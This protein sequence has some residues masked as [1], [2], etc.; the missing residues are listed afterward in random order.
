MVEE[1]LVG[2]KL[3]D[4]VMREKLTSGGMAHIYLGE[5]EKLQRR[6]AIKIL[7]S[8]MAGDDAVL[9][10][11][12]EREARAV[13]QLEHDNIVPIYQFGEEGNLY[14]IAM[15][16]IEGNDLADEMK[17]YRDKGD[18]MPTERMMSIMTQVAKALDH[19]HKRGIIHRDV[20]PSNV[21]LRK[22]D[23]NN[24]D[25]KAVLTDF[26]LVLWEDVDKTLGTA[27]GTPRYIS[28]EQA[29]DSQS[30][31]SQ[32]DIYSLAVIV[33]EILTGE[34]L[35]TGSTPME[36]ALS[37]IT[38]P[39]TPPRAHN[40]E[41]PQ[42]AQIEILKALQ[43]D[44]NKR[45]RSAMEFVNALKRAYD[46]PEDTR[47]PTEP[48]QQDTSTKPL[49]DD[50]MPS[51]VSAVKEKSTESLLDSWDRIP[52]PASGGIPATIPEKDMADGKSASKSTSP[53]QSN[54]QK[55]GNGLP[56]PAIGGVVVAVAII[57]AI[58]FGMLGGNNNNNDD[59]DNDAV[60]VPPANANMAINYNDTFF[61]ISNTSSNVTL[62]INNLS[63]EGD[64][65]GS[66]SGF[67]GL[68]EPGECIFARRQASNI[69]DSDIPDAWNC[70]GT[71]V[72]VESNSDT[73]WRAEIDSD[74]VFTVRDGNT[75]VDEC[76][77][78]GRIVGRAGDQLC[79]IAW[80]SNEAE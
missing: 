44:P 78:A 70:N 17:R 18:L 20:K 41:I 79:N 2:K 23:I 16:Y 55:E 48:P 46:L 62:D 10:E 26:G 36:V 14:F 35:F 53:L 25:D 59:S 51:A 69:N 5:D 54:T 22:K 47:P 30:A 67:S 7:T 28:P 15:R 64:S 71:A 33:Y 37:H 60:V 4:Y 45:H 21:L 76:P 68:L 32:S 38:E 24:P 8:D 6:A 39:P 75:V 77:T 61:A 29:T 73:F 40:P 3:G 11:R 43:K 58:A 19:A 49:R 56:L 31:L 1:N 52:S 80:T 27:F 66:T 42:D 34:V 65:G 12:F 57:L 9:R 13:A 74:E 50:D 63:I 72:F